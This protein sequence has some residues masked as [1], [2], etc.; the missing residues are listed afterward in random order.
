MLLLIR[1]FG[2]CIQVLSD[3]MGTMG[4]GYPPLIHVL[5]N[6][7]STVG[8][9]HE[10]ANHSVTKLVPPRALSASALATVEILLSKPADLKLSSADLANGQMLHVGR[11]Q[12]TRIAGAREGEIGS[13]DYCPCYWWSEGWM[14][15]EKLE[16]CRRSGRCLFE[17]VMGTVH[18]GYD[19]VVLYCREIE[20]DC[21]LF[22]R[23]SHVLSLLFIP[24]G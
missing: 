24:A 15:A 19:C 18:A 3:A 10:P 6:P 16:A 17:L 5:T 21:S 9:R 11:G 7:I 13:I 14:P 8:R 4:Y 22:A 1:E 12:Q 23:D 20:N 2:T